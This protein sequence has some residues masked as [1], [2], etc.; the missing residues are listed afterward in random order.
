VIVQ[1]EWSHESEFAA[2][3]SSASDARKFVSGLLSVHGLG[4]LGGDVELVV[5]ELATNALV[6]ADTSFTVVLGA[7]EGTV[8]LEVLDGS[9]V[10]PAFVVARALEINGRGL[11]IVQALSRDWGVTANASGGK[12]VWA[13]FAIASASL[14]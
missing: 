14:P 11:V 5:S 3:A 4:H 12:S 10:G 8:F 2:E 1:R 7:F 13:E 9:H 6:H